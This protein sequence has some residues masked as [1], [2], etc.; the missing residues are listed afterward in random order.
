[1]RVT[2]DTNVLLRAILQDDDRQTEAAEA[3]L[4]NATTIAVPVPVFC[5]MSWALRRS[6][7]QT[8]PEVAA[9]IQA[10]CAIETVV[11]DGPAV[12]AGVE[13]LLAGGDFADGAI[14]QQGERLGATVFA[15]FDRK[16][17]ANLRQAGLAAQDPAELVE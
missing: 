17:A 2:A 4:A 13:A 7:H 12:E 1:M 10:I 3:L 16:A 9:A 8:P 5:E 15:T 14:A 11:T 6:F